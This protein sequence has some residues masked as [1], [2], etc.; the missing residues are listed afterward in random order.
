MAD[1][2]AWANQQLQTLL[3]FEGVNDILEHIMRLEDQE[4]P[5]YLHGLLGK[6]SQVNK[7]INQ[8]KEKRKK[9]TPGR[10][11]V[12]IGVQI[13]QKDKDDDLPGKRGKKKHGQSA[14]SSAVVS[15]GH[16]EFDAVH[17]TAPSSARKKRGNKG[18]SSV[19]VD[20]ADHLLLPG[21]AECECQG[22]RHSALTNC[23]GC[24]KIIC[25]QEG[26]G[27]CF[28]CGFVVNPPR[29]DKARSVQLEKAIQHKDTLLNYDRTS[30]QRTVVLD[31]QSDY[32]SV[33]SNQWLS[34]AERDKI[35]SHLM[36]QRAKAEALKNKH[37][38][39]FDFAGRRVVVDTPPKIDI[40]LPTTSLSTPETTTTPT[41]PTN[42]TAKP[43]P[44]KATPL[45]NPHIDIAQPKFVSDKKTPTAGKPKAS[46]GKQLRSSKRIQH[47]YFGV[48]D[49]QSDDDD[50]NNNPHTPWKICGVI[51]GVWMHEFQETSLQEHATN[52]LNKLLTAM[53]AKGMNHFVFFPDKRALWREK[54]VKRTENEV[55]NLH[56]TCTDKHINLACGIVLD[57]AVRLMSTDDLN[58]LVA[59]I[60]FLVK[61]GINHISLFLNHVMPGG[62]DQSGADF[63]VEQAKFLNVVASEVQTFSNSL[64]EQTIHWYILPTYFYADFSDTAPIPRNQVEYWKSF[65]KTLDQKF[66]LYFHI[67]HLVKYAPKIPSFFPNRRLIALEQFPDPSL[68]L[69]SH[70]LFIPL[71]PY[72]PSEGDLEKLPSLV[73]GMAASTR[74]LMYAATASEWNLVQLLTFLDFARNLAKYRNMVS[75]KAALTIVLKDER[76]VSD[77]LDIISTVPSSVAASE[78]NT[79]QISS[80]FAKIVCR[81][82]LEKLVHVKESQG[83]DLYNAYL[84]RVEQFLSSISA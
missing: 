20:D 52:T 53:S 28:F 38:I 67:N 25:E 66:H 54:F 33:E 84:D 80:H 19:N 77:L 79:N 71:E 58:L 8:L 6:T 63:A 17:H 78:A 10:F 74:T 59:K 12:P 13:Y 16:V 73:Y 39:T 5:N 29:G 75:L 34:K 49:T 35:S 32:F 60:S 21:R 31:D 36:L 3:G 55:T 62:E 61:L 11:E 56:K 37:T 70:S 45:Y 65:N 26:Y 47:Q 57:A 9:F 24:G 41:N 51:E 81:E 40:S 46:E 7:F 23:I 76:I 30:A 22:T 48:D 72:A 69:S 64:D 44:A 42:P 14:G 1:L 68:P 43:K 82:L 4:L 27:K 83:T 50:D 15:S 18:K 2:H